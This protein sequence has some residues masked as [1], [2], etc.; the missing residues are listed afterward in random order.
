MRQNI[1]KW[2]RHID[3]LSWGGFLKFQKGMTVQAYNDISK[4]VFYLI[5]YGLENARLSPTVTDSLFY[6]YRPVEEGGYSE[7]QTKFREVLMRMNK[8]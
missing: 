1:I 4:I 8:A 5:I 6:G 3:F 7:V 2:F